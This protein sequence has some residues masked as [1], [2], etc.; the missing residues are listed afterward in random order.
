LPAAAAAFAA[1]V[2]VAFGGLPLAV[3]AVAGGMAGLAFVLKD[4]AGVARIARSAADELVRVLNVMGAAAGVLRPLLEP[5]A[6]AFGRLAKAVADQLVR[7]VL[8]GAAGLEQVGGAVVT[9][10]DALADAM[11][12]LQPVFDK[13]A[14]VVSRFV[15]TVTEWVGGW[16]AEAV[17]LLADLA[18]GLESL[19]DA[20]GELLGAGFGFVAEVF[21]AMVG[22]VGELVGG[23]DGLND[24]LTGVAGVVRF[25]AREV[26]PALATGIARTVSVVATVFGYLYQV[27]DALVAP[28]RQVVQA[29]AGLFSKDNYDREGVPEDRYS[30]SFKPGAADGLA[31]RG[32]SSGS[33]SDAIRRAQEAA[34]GSG[35][36]PEVQTAK[37]VMDMGKT[38]GEIKT[39]IM[40]LPQ[41]LAE[42]LALFVA[43]NVPGV[44]TAGRVYDRA[45]NAHEWAARQFVATITG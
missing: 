24:A 34:F 28:S 9:V 25:V 10:L 15:G 43:N 30:R 4:T 19:A 7:A 14:G 36:R 41:S 13:A 38:L 45:V 21:E 12:P 39:E 20:A 23:A 17:G 40:N 44:Q 29:L 3:G 22:S 26:L 8:V 6:N 27:L 11:G 35:Q 42:K 18:P 16:L 5:A 33:Q 2:S 1:A 37:G 32:V 31:V